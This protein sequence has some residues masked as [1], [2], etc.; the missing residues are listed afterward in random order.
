MRSKWIGL[1]LVVLLAVFCSFQNSLAVVLKDAN[2]TQKEKYRSGELLVKFK[3]GVS[4]TQKK[5]IHKRHGAS[6]LR[7][8]PGLRLE[9]VKLKGLSVEEALARYRGDADVEYAEPDYTVS[10]QQTPNDPKFDSQWGLNNTGQFGGV[11]G[12]DI[13]AL[14]AWDHTTG[15]DNVV[16]AVVDSGIDY[17]HPDLAANMWVNPGEIPGN[18]IDDDNNG[19]VDDVYGINTIVPSGDPMDDH[20]HGT[21]VAGIIGAVGNNSIGVAGVAWDV[22]IMACKFIGNNGVGYISDAIECLQYIK[23]MKNRGENVIATNNSWGA[24][25]A[26]QALTDAIQAQSDILFVAAAA[27]DKADLDR[28]AYS[29]AGIKLPNILS[30]A[31][32][33][34]KDAMASFSNFGRASVLLGAP[35]FEID[36]TIS[37]HNIWGAVDYAR[38]SGTS[39]AAPH[40][41]G[42]AALLKSADL[43]RDSRAIRNLILA[44]ADPLAALAQTTATGRRE[45]A[46][47]SLTCTD[48]HVLAV[49]QYPS[50]APTYSVGVP[51]TLS[52]ISINCAAPVG[53]VSL[54]TAG[55]EQLALL[56]D[57]VFPDVVAG[58]GTFT[59]RWTPSQAGEVLT[60][61]SP[62]GSQTVVAPLL[63]V[64]TTGLSNGFLDKPYSRTLT[65]IGGIAPYRWVVSDGALPDGLTLDADTGEIRGI[66]T[67]YGRFRFRVTVTDVSQ[68]E[69]TKE[70]S[71]V[72]IMENNLS[73]AW[74]KTLDVGTLVDTVEGMA[75]D[76]QGNILITGTAQN[77]TDR[78]MDDFTAKLDPSGAVLWTANYPGSGEEQGHRV[79][80]DAV[81]NAYVGG[82]TN[83]GNAW[84]YL[85]LKYDPAGNL[86]WSRTGNGIT[87]GST[88]VA[89]DGMGNLYVSASSYVQPDDACQ[90]F[91]YSPDGD[92]LWQRNYQD[93][94]GY[95]C[96]SNGITVGN[97]GYVY[98]VGAIYDYA[99]LESS[100]FVMKYDPAG[101]LVW[102]SKYKHPS[103]AT[104]TYDFAFAVTADASG[105]LYLTGGGTDADPLPFPTPTRFGLVW[106]L[107]SS[108]ALRWVRRFNTSYIVGGEEGRGIALNGAG[109]LYVVQSIYD[110]QPQNAGQVS[111]LIYDVSGNYLG[112]KEYGTP[113]M[114]ET[115]HAIAIDQNG[116]IYLAG[117]TVGWDQNY[118]LVVK[119]TDTFFIDSTTL[120]AGLRGVPYA[121]SLSAAGGSP[122]YHWVLF[123]GSLPP[124]LVLDPDSGAIAGVP[125]VPGTFDFI[126]SVKDSA[127]AAAMVAASI[128]AYEPL[129]IP[130]S[131]LSP[132]AVGASYS[133]SM[134][135]TGGSAPY[136]WSVAAG[137]LPSGLNLG[138]AGDISGTPTTA[139]SYVFTALV[140]DALGLSA[141]RELSIT[142]NPPLAITPLDL[143]PIGVKGQPYELALA[144]TGGVIPYSWSVVSGSLP[145]GLSLQP[146]SGL[147]NGTPSQTGNATFTMR[148]SD[149]TTVTAEKTFTIFVY[150]PLVITTESLDLGTVGV[151]YSKTL[152]TS[153][154]HTPYTW[155]VVAGSLPPG[156]N[157]STT[158]GSIS[159]TPT[160]V[161]S[162]FFT[163]KVV[164][165]IGL[166]ATREFSLDIYTPLVITNMDPSYEGAITGTPYSFQLAAGGGKAPYT[167]SIASGTLPAGLSLNAATGLIEGTPSVT[168]SSTF[169]TRVTDSVAVKKDRIFTIAVYDPLII[170][171]AALPAGNTGMAY[172]LTLTST[173]GGPG[174][175]VWQI[176]SGTLPPNLTLGFTTGLISGTPISSNSYT[177]SVSVFDGNNH[178]DVKTFT[179]VV[180][181]PLAI[182]VSSVFEIP[183]GGTYWTLS[184]SSGGYPLTWSIISGNLPPGLS[185]NATS[186]VVSGSTSQVGSYPL[187]LRVTDCVQQTADKAI[188]V[189]VFDPVV[190]TTTVAADGVT[191]VPY[192]QELTA[193]AGRPPHSWGI[194]VYDLPPGL[195][196]NAT[197]GT[198]SGTPSQAGSWSFFVQ[199]TDSYGTNSTTTDSQYLT[200]RVSDPLAIT[201]TSA[202]DTTSSSNYYLPLTASGGKTP[203]TW[204][205][206]SGTLPPGLA[207]NASS[208]LISGTVADTAT[209][210]FS[211]SAQVTDSL[212]NKSTGPLSITIYSIPVITTLT[213]PDGM[214]GTPYNLTLA[215]SGG[216]LPYTWRVVS[217][218]LPPGLTL[219]A[220][221]GIISGTPTAGGV[222]PA[223]ILLTDAFGSLSDATISFGIAAKYWIK[224]VTGTG[225][226]YTSGPKTAKL[227]TAS[228]D[229]V[230]GDTLSWAFSGQKEMLIGYRAGGYTTKTSVTGAKA[231]TSLSFLAKNT[232]GTGYVHLVEVNQT[233]GKVIRKLASLSVPLSSNVLTTVSDI[234]RL[235]GTVNAGNSFGIMLSMST[236]A[237]STNVVRWGK[238]GGGAA[239][240][241]WFAV[242]ETP[243]P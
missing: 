69:Y 186:G 74:T 37:S 240:E 170:T 78:K 228:G 243:V 164:D 45:N 166:S 235:A 159:G 42:L 120:T 17:Q 52:V 221:T 188:T 49:V 33:D 222:F 154:G 143:V 30:V 227:G 148:V 172:S 28:T 26:S 152:A 23:A 237:K 201:T 51:T 19:Y 208:G 18:G 150:Y 84:D 91:K 79:A 39:M 165:F 182:T 179:I 181:S 213:A 76:G 77:A 32:T 124:G 238:T 15:A 101:N 119:Y 102:T 21:H 207:L 149:S 97:D 175:R 194:L 157:L 115:G 171:T 46:S 130:M 71:I 145:L 136:A 214:A 48:S 50:T 127:G 44:G 218:N 177:F 60:F 116:G 81:G 31:A 122:P 217:G 73:V 234:S 206:A 200:I 140:T 106:K 229:S 103:T 219:D 104:R 6:R 111:T 55:G 61:S 158:Y 88:G 203:Y 197:T 47:G 114:H 199:V 168:G 144:A 43:A 118:C 96:V 24:P 180:Y 142:I 226:T 27:N 184:V 35:G 137:S 162:Y 117:S 95:F 173:G 85:V 135:A 11:P 100:A 20:G 3:P 75:L 187:T 225:K 5:N 109:R 198:I 2:K 90:L 189:V 93:A 54:T 62:L 185:L 132:G 204:S 155:S 190:I 99:M 220:A 125:T 231:G 94:A 53:P 67:M 241:Q 123:Q 38:L 113:T 65:A 133:S 153:N 110:E 129:T 191:G 56:D 63:L 72:T 141:T 29:P 211:F 59:C 92:L 196:L 195:T 176:H 80:V 108:G 178:H 4:E 98:P 8:F 89:V 215:A 34:R 239:F 25:G 87:Y 161:G 107:S 9:E 183:T 134:A 236:K 230:T 210:T 7:T 66:P 82:I 209:G 146:S 58:D 13:D 151:F 86:I 167:W 112:S 68:M 40:V 174:N 193:S 232:A 57:G 242:T 16:V 41:A 64:T 121:K 147:I 22:R 138:N 105:D 139:G 163:V 36:S 223:E 126:V 12:A 192:S 1:F 156:M 70:L 205:I 131:T 160:T 128:I 10:V 14:S 233:S 216:K 169:T 83:N 202:P 212:G 224:T